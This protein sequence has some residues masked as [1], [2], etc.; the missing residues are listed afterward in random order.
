MPTH[1]TALVVAGVIVAMV[2]TLTA[3][4]L[5]TS[6]IW[7]AKMANCAYK[8]SC[9]CDGKSPNCDEGCQRDMPSQ[10]HCNNHNN[11]CHR[12]C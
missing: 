7:D 4:S 1:A 10:G 9:W 3:R 5:R 8:N 11:G 6:V 2:V 12:N